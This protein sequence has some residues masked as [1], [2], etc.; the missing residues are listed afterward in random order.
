MAGLKDGLLAPLPPQVTYFLAGRNNSMKNA[1]KAYVPQYRRLHST[2]QLGSSYGRR[3]KL[4]ANTP[5]TVRADA[6]DSVQMDKPGFLF[7]VIQCHPTTPPPIS[8]VNCSF[9][10]H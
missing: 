10:G 6:E 7:S 9:Q 3:R 4:S 8:G 2:D 5:Q 1:S